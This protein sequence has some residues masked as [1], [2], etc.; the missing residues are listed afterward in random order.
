MSIT[1]IQTPPQSIDHTSNGMRLTAEEFDAL[2]E[3]EPGFRYELIHG[4]LIVTP[5]AGPGERSPNDDLGFLLRNFRE[6][7]ANGFLLDET[8]PEQEIRIGDNR[9]RAD[10]AVWV[11]LGHRPDPLNDVPAIAIEF[12]SASS[13]DRHRDY[14]E[15]RDEYAQAGIQ[16]YW[17][18][19]RFRREMTVFRGTAEVVVAENEIYSTPLL[20]EFELPLSRL[21]AAA[22]DY[23][24]SVR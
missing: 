18:I 3:W 11:G 8:L 20:P 23:P 5:P 15:K 16:E 24:E 12:V 9:R 19:D 7:H 17:V 13:R 22:D 10:R 2:E 21:L 14:V 6:N 1:D 4:V